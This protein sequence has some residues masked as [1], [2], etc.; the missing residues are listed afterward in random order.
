[1]SLPTAEACASEPAACLEPGVGRINAGTRKI[2][3]KDD[4]LKGYLTRLFGV[5]AFAGLFFPVHDTV[6]AADMPLAQAINM[7]GR[8]RM[9]TQRIVKAYLQVGQGI[10]PEVSRRQLNDA[11]LLF[12]AQLADLKKF[13]LDKRSE[14]SFARLEKWWRPFKSAALGNV[15]RGGAERLLAMDDE[16]VGA[17]HELTVELQNRSASPAG[18]LVNISGRQRMLSQRLAKYYLLRAWGLESPAVSREIGSA[19]TE[20]DGALATLRSAPDNTAEIRRELDAVALQWE[21]FQNALAL[22]GAA[23]YGLIVVNAAEAILNSME[24]VT[25]LY[26]RL[27]AR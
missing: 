12:E 14:P 9:L 25:G 19:R 22:E 7:S 23:S 13:A 10:T 5:L 24:V 1:M 16:L 6:G 8:Q 2:A 18:R 20:F 17:A 15:D 3:G 4:R 27:P 21:W 26:E 11:V